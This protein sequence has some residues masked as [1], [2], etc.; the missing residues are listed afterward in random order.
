MIVVGD[1]I[2]I[3]GQTL[4]V[5]AIWAQGKHTTYEMSDGTHVIDLMQMIN[6]GRASVVKKKTPIARMEERAD[7][8]L[9][10]NDEDFEE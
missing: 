6:D 2:N 1:N 7:W 10:V 3:G 8:K 4:T 9:P 5:S